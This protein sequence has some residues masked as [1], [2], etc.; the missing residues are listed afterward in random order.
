MAATAAT[1]A[2]RGAAAA[3]ARA[4]ARARAGDGRGAGLAARGG[5][6]GRAARARAGAGGS[7]PGPGQGAGGEEELE[8]ALLRD[9][10]QFRAREGGGAPGALGPA[11]SPGPGAAGGPQGSAMASDGAGF[12]FLDKLLIADFVFILFALAWLV[13]GVAQ[14]ATAGDSFLFESWFKLWKPVFQPALGVFM[15]AAIFSALK[16]KFQSKE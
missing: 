11:G 3:R 8:E 5:R 10:E 16:G 6:G 4:R 15:L 7:G 9:L 12:S 2:P 14:N 13:A 1:D